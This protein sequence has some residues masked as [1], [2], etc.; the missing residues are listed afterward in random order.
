[1]IKYV[2]SYIIIYQHILVATAI[3]IRKSYKNTNNIQT[4]AQNIKLCYCYKQVELGMF[5]LLL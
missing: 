4:I 2:L 3:V 5:M 1:M